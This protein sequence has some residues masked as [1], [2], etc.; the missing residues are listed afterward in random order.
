M[1]LLSSITISDISDVSTIPSPKGRYLQVKKRVSYG[2]SFCIHGKIT[3]THLDKQFISDPGHAII[4]PK[5]ADYMLYGNETGLFP[6]INFDCTET[7]TDTFLSIPLHNPESYLGDCKRIADS[8]LFK[9]HR[10]RAMSI[11]YDILDRLSLESFTGN[12][13]LDIAVSCIEQNYGDSHL[14]NESLACVAGIS[15]VYLRRLF[16]DCFGMP[17]R[18]YL[19]DIRIRKARQLLS[20]QH[21]SVTQIAEFCGFTSLYHFSRAFHDITG[22]TP[23]AYRKAT[24]DMPI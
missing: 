10:A 20:E 7:F 3:Y 12:R 11:L 16:K 13:A 9:K 5:G 23:T 19:L 24:Q 4:L 18:Q 15:E 2:L 1:N 8:L 6:L 21:Y 14:T 22:S 17:P